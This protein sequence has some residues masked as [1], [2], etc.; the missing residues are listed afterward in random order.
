[1]AKVTITG[2][3]PS[4]AQ[5]KQPSYRTF[6]DAAGTRQR[7]YDRS[8]KAAQEF[9]P[10]SNQRFTIS[11]SEPHYA[12]E[13][14]YSYA[15][16][17]QAILGRRSL[18][19]E[20]RGTWQLSD[21]ETGAV[22]AKKKSR[23]GMIPYMTN[24]GT[25]IN[26]GNEYTMSHQMRL[27]P[28]V[29]TRVKDNGELEA[30]V[31]VLPGK[32]RSHRIFLD[33]ESGVF[34]IQLGQARI[35]LL[36]LLRSMQVT[37]AQLRGAWGNDLTAVNMEK[38]DPK[39]LSKLADRLTQGGLT[40]ENSKR[41]AIAAA[42]SSMEL[43]PDVT[44]R[45]L[46][47][48]YSNL[49]AEA[50]LDITRKLLAVSK[51]EAEPDDRDHLAYQTFMGP[52]DIFSER[53][54]R[55]RGAVRR[56]LWKA[57]A[58]GKL[59][60]LSPGVFDDAINAGLLSSGLGMPLEEI[61]PA[62]LFDQQGRVTRMGD[63]GIGS[64]DQ[65][66]DD[67]RAVQ[68]SQLGFIDFLRTPESAKAGVDLRMARG[69][70]KGENGEIY[71][72][73]VDV[74]SGKTVYKTPQD[75]ADA[76]I[77]FPGELRRTAD[78][79]AHVAAMVGGKARMI[80]RQ[81]VQFELPNMEDTFSP[82][83]NMIPMK[84]MVKGQRAVMAARML[85]QA[86]PL[87]NPEAPLVQSGMPGQPGRS[88]E[89]AYGEHFA[90]VRSSAGGRV[91]GVFPDRITLE[92]PEG[93]E[94]VEL[95]QNFPFNRKTFLHHTPAVKAGDQVQVGQV[96][97][98][99]NYTDAAGAAALGKNARV[100]YIPFGG[101]N[102]EDAV[103]IGESF[104]KR[105]T[106]EHMYQH[107]H[108]WSPEHRKG[109]NTFVG[110][111]PTAYDR[112]TLDRFDES[113]VVESGTEVKKGDPLVLAAR[114][115]VPTRNAILRRRKPSFINDTITWNHESPGIV[116][117]TYQDDGGVHVVVKSKSE[118]EVGDKLSGRF[119]DKGVVSRIVPDAQ[120]PTDRD[121]R[122]YEVLMNPLGI[123]SRTNPAQIIEAA[124]GKIAAVT[125]KPYKLVDFEDIDDA[126]EFTL[127][128]LRQH[129]MQGLEDVIDQATGRKIA[130]VFTGNRWL[131]KLH[132]TS[133]SKAQGR[134]L[135]SYTTEGVPA[136]GGEGG[137]KRLGM[138][139]TNSLLSHGATDV[140][141]DASLVRGQASP[142]YWAQ[143]MSGNKPP[144]PEV[145]F[146]YKKFV[147]EL[148]ASGINVV[149]DGSA[150]HIMAL[151][152]S[153][154]GE[155]AGNREIQNTETVDWR[156]GL[157]PKK[158]GLFDEA[159]TGGHNGTRWS[160]IPLH[161]PL[162]NPV[163]E[164]PIR[165]VLG[166]TKR[167]LSEVISGKTALGGHRGPKA[168]Q[169]ALD[170]IDL[171]KEIERARA[172]IKSS[173][174][175]QRDAAQRRLGYLRDAER[176]GI[177]PRDWVI[178][179]AP[180]LPPAFRPISTMGPRKLPM[181]ADPNFLYKEL[182]DANRSLRDMS[183]DLGDDVGDERLAVYQALKGVVGLGDPIHPR[184][185][186]R[187]VRG[188]LKHVFGHSPKVGVVQRRLLGSS[189][190]FVGR[191]VITPNPDLDMDQVGIPE[192]KAWDIYTPFIVRNLVRKGMPRFQAARATEARS[193][194]ARKALLA[195]M[196]NRPVII[197]RAPTLHR[198]G[199]MAAWPRLTKSKTLEVSP[200]VV[201]GF[202]AD[203]D[204]D[205]MNYHVP[206]TDEAAQEAEEKMLP[207]RNLFN[208]ADFNV[209]YQPSHEYTGGLYEA[210]ARVDEQGART[211]E[212]REAAIRAYRRG[213]I[214][215]G[216][217]I[218]IL[219]D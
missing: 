110:I 164:E 69:A 176:L 107:S 39:A 109:K 131:M 90:S 61:N 123:E 113:G 209:L 72:P 166:I 21:N 77:A 175:T 121:G 134:G 208:A 82:L 190:D 60:K 183:R 147:N 133:E 120:M 116:T 111:F 100:A 161:E 124:L 30:H 115:R 218:N 79:R 48:R 17:K 186:E 169:R 31:N 177:H 118:M 44:A 35:P 203:F 24:R 59:D 139:E 162:P 47:K 11:L 78:P 178:S 33:P 71:S 95:Y 135:G 112:Q 137:S 204:G 50:I 81:Q 140:I 12:N 9:E 187:Q 145:P 160:Y 94:E 127:R 74:A 193:P 167:Q 7:I 103:V 152:D 141:R 138:L 25:F 76:T 157:K 88:F 172:E 8:L 6:G 54:S 217:K 219:E 195:S 16:Q 15:D 191:S 70:V 117:D 207:S 215:V 216:Q 114:E 210:S 174:R 10:I 67:A 97:A 104:A 58:T 128:E 51:Q 45:T 92:G 192:D 105:M 52:E 144:T 158:G 213:D 212:S 56:A 197:N 65:I 34:R 63:G 18:G 83:G 181:V 32:G 148:K 129:N 200:L 86:L 205:A 102:F 179:K 101:L 130:D 84:S 4:P 108:E 93:R 26:H 198:Y 22:L 80:P 98:T 119:G 155:L 43:D 143:F 122:P 23:L 2:L 199:M 136:R 165:R 194:E 99:S 171:K 57:S 75:L 3:S 126:T 211:F 89:E 153:D 151:T 185:K 49:S 146:V 37:D 62:D 106:S 188:I 53:I 125:G 29:F 27:R 150:V 19:R 5:P 41:D 55:A 196:E 189:V 149:R 20:L 73:V 214:G 14:E 168:V 142:Q 40:D 36:P 156:A 201:G 154:I 1:M 173:K 206:T 184:N 96:L 202:N 85:T 42:M 91:V 87:T 13:D 182:F 28:G 170:R 68:P 159:L 180:V 38:D 46:G 163:M 132:H 64:I 66:T